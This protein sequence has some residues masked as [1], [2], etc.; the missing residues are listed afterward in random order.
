LA[1]AGLAA[2]STEG[3]ANIE[4]GEGEIV[5]NVLANTAKV[6]DD[7]LIFPREMFPQQLRDRIT[8]YVKEIDDGKKKEEIENVILV[9][10]RQQNATDASGRIREGLGNPYGY[11]RR[12]LSFRD[13]GDKTIVMTEDA[14]LEDAVK[15]IDASETIEIGARDDNEKPGA[16]KEQ[17]SKKLSF[18]IPAVNVHDKDIWRKGPAFIRIKSGEMKIK[19]TIDLGVNIHLLKGVTHAHA[20][21]SAG[22]ESEL[23]LEA[24]GEAGFSAQP[25]MDVF[26]PMSWPVGSIGPVPVTLTLKASVVCDASVEGRFVTNGGIRANVDAQAGISYDR[27]SGVKPTFEQ[28]RFMPSLVMPKVET[29]VNGHA[30][31]G[32]RPELSLLLAGMAGPFVAS[33]GYARVNVDVVPPPMKTNLHAGVTVDVGGKLSVFGK[34]LGKVVEKQ[35][36][37]FDK[38]LWHN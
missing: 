12:A 18:T 34:D 16:V 32:L 8:S 11:L 27:G 28:P 26:G 23:I 17:L 22:L 29:S 7:R 37:S 35:V 38:E 30:Q 4:E 31:C 3:E 10:D 25:T 15:E 14:T 6:E 13:E 24:G 36:Y 33:T 19:T 1:V 9:S 5:A 2:C 21:I 20:I